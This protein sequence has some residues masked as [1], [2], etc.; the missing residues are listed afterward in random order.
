MTT[1]QWTSEQIREE[2]LS[3][4]ES[5]SH[6]R[7]A[8]SSLIPVGDPTLLLANAGMNQFKPYFAGET[9]PPNVRLTSSQK[10][11]RTVDIDIVGDATHCTL[12]EML[13]NFS[14]G[15][16]FKQ[17]AI[18]FALEFLTQNMGLPKD[19]LRLLQKAFMET[20]KDPKF[21]RE[22]KKSQL[23][24]NPLDGAKLAKK[25]AGFYNYDSKLLAR[26]KEIIEPKK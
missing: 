8:S 17:G 20:M 15:D 3:F 4:F 21:L 10:A 23:E 19:R 5:K 18:E 13:G 25:F 16:Y 2:F 22:A 7:V 14:I 1:R 6:L 9:E 24:I 12:F 11:F 26:V